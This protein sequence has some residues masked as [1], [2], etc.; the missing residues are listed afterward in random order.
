[1]R[2]EV[3][4]IRLGSLEGRDTLIWNENKAQT[5]SVRTAYHVALRMNRI[6][7]G[8]HSRVQEG[9]PVWNQLWKLFVPPKV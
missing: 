5:F 6:G 4:R 7:I 1:M 8:E 3:L 9:K 2:D